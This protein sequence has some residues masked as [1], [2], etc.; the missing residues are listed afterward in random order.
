MYLFM[1]SEKN[2]LTKVMFLTKQI[3][4]F[5]LQPASCDLCKMVVKETRKMLKS[6][7][8]DV[9]CK[10]FIFLLSSLY[11][12]FNKLLLLQLN[13]HQ[14]HYKSKHYLKVGLGSKIIAIAG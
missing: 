11:H 14:F 7:S 2:K 6:K 12:L 5:S 4:F 1:N 10:L 3:F 9:C 8:R 13:C